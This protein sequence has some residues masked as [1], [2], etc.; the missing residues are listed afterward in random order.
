MQRGCVISS[1]LKLVRLNLTTS[2]NHPGSLLDGFHMRVSYR[3]SMLADKPN[4][5]LPSLLRS[6]DRSF[7][8]QAVSLSQSFRVQQQG[9]YQ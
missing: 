4:T 7:Q 3:Y 5:P 2:A 9:F 1:H 8:L 6:L